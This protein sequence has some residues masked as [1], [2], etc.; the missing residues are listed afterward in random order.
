MR[1]KRENEGTGEKITKVKR[2]ERG[3]RGEVS[4]IS[5][6]E[7]PCSDFFK[8]PHLLFDNFEVFFFFKQQ[9]QLLGFLFGWFHFCLLD[10]GF[11]CKSCLIS[12]CPKH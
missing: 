3:E 10:S 6:I 11:N 7:M 9:Q 1:M 12:F 8:S 4:E 2:E 5:C